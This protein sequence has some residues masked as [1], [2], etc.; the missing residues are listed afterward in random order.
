MRALS[1]SSI[2][3]RAAGERGRKI[4][5]NGCRK[6]P[7]GFLPAAQERAKEEAADSRPHRY[8]SCLAENAPTRESFFIALQ[9]QVVVPCL[10][11]LLVLLLQFEKGDVMVTD[12]GA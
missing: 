4:T 1:V 11:K 12:D 9:A 7:T 8:W 3:Y 5:G 2:A 10:R 6:K